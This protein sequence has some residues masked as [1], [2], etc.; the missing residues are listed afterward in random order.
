MTGSERAEICQQSH[1]SVTGCNISVK[2]RFSDLTKE[3]IGQDWQGKDI[4]NECQGKALK[5]GCCERR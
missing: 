3:Q 2:N 4:T 1:V 5:E